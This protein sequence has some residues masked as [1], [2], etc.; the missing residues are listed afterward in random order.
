MKY[1]TDVRVA[2]EDPLTPRGVLQAAWNYP[3][4]RAFFEEDPSVVVLDTTS[5]TNKPAPID[6]GYRKNG[7]R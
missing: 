2:M 3:S 6:A 4:H 1:I 7:S 5:N